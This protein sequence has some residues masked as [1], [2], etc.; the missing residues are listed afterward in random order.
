MILAEERLRVATL[1]GCERGRRSNVRRGSGSC[2][3]K[4]RG[5]S[6]GGVGSSGRE[7]WEDAALQDRRAA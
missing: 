2:A 1:S 7:A 4:G 5:G 6:G 3:L